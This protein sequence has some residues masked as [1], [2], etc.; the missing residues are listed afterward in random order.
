MSIDRAKRA[1]RNFRGVDPTEVVHA[2]LPDKAVTAYHMGDVEGIMY[3][4]E[5]DGKTER[6]MH[7]F[8]GAAGPSLVVQ[9]DG[10]Q[11]YLTGG[12][13]RVT[14][15]GIE[16]NKM[17][18]MLIVNPRKRG[19]KAKKVVNPM[20]VK[21]RRKATK[22]K[23]RNSTRTIVVRANPVS[24]LRVTRKRRRRAFAAAPVRTRRR[25][26]RN[27]IGGRS[28]GGKGDIDLLGLLVAAT[29]QG[30]GGV[31]T[32]ALF[33][34]LP[35]PANLKTGPFAGFVK[36]SVGVAAGMVI[37]KFVNKK[38]GQ[39]FAEG[40]ITIAAFDTIKGY[41]PSNVPLGEFLPSG[42]MGEFIRPGLG[43]VSASQLAPDMSYQG[44]YAQ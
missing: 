17:P 37:A 18:P 36:A 2:R 16:D 4:T 20:A 40:A 1:Y 34:M 35:I 44:I 10:S 23:R 7:K 21:R 43:Y 38:L 31:A 9:D 42:G 41:V 19:T 25:Y 27:P 22:T 29:I 8:K 15:R 13:Y 11:M 32:S 12:N 3:K 5:R 26:R 28:M 14:E 6:Y 30:A 33:A 24:P 39:S